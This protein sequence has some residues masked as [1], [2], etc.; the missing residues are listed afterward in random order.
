LT[1]N[2]HR[3][4]VPV[5]RC[6]PVRACNGS[7]LG[8]S[9]LKLRAPVAG[10]C[11]G[12]ATGR[13]W[14]WLR[15]GLRQRHEPR[16]EV[17]QLPGL[18]HDAHAGQQG[19][20]AGHPGDGFDHVVEVALGRRCT[21]SAPGDRLQVPAGQPAVGGEALGQD[22]QVAA[23]RG[24]AVVVEDQPAS[25]VASGSFFADIVIPSARAAICRTFP[26]TGTSA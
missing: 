4:C 5:G 1:R 10:I 15:L 16:G 26:A 2:E 18:G 23:L 9:H 21:R 17:P 13:R 11:G 7:G 3:E 25:D 12:G 22:L 8:A 19:G 24:Q 20:P 6:E 14:C